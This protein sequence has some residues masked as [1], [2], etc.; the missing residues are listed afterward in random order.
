MSPDLES[1]GAPGD[2]NS[3]VVVHVAQ[4]SV[5]AHLLQHHVSLPFVYLVFSC[6]PYH[7]GARWVCDLPEGRITKRIRIAIPNASRAAVRVELRVV[8]LLERE[9]AH[10]KQQRASGKQP[11]QLGFLPLLE[12]ATARSS[13]R[14]SASKHHEPPP[15]ASSWSAVIEPSAYAQVDLVPI[16]H[17]STSFLIQVLVD[18]CL[19]YEWSAVVLHQ[20]NN[21][22]KHLRPDSRVPTVCRI[23]Q[24]S[25]PPPQRALGANNAP[26]PAISSPLP[27][28]LL[29]PP[30]SSSLYEELC[31]PLGADLLAECD[32]L[33][34]G[35]VGR[36]RPRSCSD[37]S[38][39][40]QSPSSLSWYAMAS[41]PSA[42]A[43]ASSW[44]SSL[45]SSISSP[46]SMMMTLEPQAAAA[47]Y[48]SDLESPSPKRHAPSPSAL[49]LDCDLQSLLLYSSDDANSSDGSEMLP[50]ELADM[51]RTIDWHSSSPS[52]SPSLE[53]C[54]HLLL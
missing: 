4:A 54:D 41:S 40:H 36:K 3:A 23:G 49:L 13:S 27:P 46:S 51:L 11:S 35:L 48:I 47:L 28:Q 20:N 30:S 12:H 45:A 38:D 7:H 9:S 15:I 53:P 24:W 14:S 1:A 50:N 25:P 8:S 52:S 29:S 44:P 16:Y 22:Q 21:Q 42:S 19:C 2:A 43:S 5:V 6:S 37:E 26:A 17:S 18:G 10:M 33:F 39:E 32:Q 34:S 31:E